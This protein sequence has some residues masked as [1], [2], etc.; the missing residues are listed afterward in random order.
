VSASAPKTKLL[1]ANNKIG[2][3]RSGS[4]NPAGDLAC[5]AE[6]MPAPPGDHTQLAVASC[7]WTFR[8]KPR[9]YRGRLKMK[10]TKREQQ[11]VAILLEGRSNKEIARRLG[12]TEGTVKLHLHSVF[13]KT[14]VIRRVALVAKVMARRR[15]SMKPR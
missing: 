4:N 15:R 1:A 8:K 2:T 10:L 12:I 5:L 6:E 13:Q 11:V 14:G 3:G 9:E 7:F